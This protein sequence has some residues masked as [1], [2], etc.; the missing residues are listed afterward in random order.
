LIQLQPGHRVR[1]YLYQ[2]HGE[3][4]APLGG[5]EANL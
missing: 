1:C 4:R 3:H 5:L 2:S